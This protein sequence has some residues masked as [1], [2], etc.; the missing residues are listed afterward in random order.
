VAVILKMKD[1]CSANLTFTAHNQQNKTKSP[2][3]A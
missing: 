1:T 2:K 3:T